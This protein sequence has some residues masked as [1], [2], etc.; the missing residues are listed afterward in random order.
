[1]SIVD[2]V[3][4]LARDDSGV[5]AS[6]FLP[7]LDDEVYW[8]VF[9]TPKCRIVTVSEIC[10]MCTYWR[11]ALGKPHVMSKADVVDIRRELEEIIKSKRNNVIRNYVHYE[12]VTLIDRQR[13]ID[14]MRRTS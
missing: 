5:Y 9:D 11:E 10:D 14:S 8:R 4:E 2:K 7:V 13:E 3:L 6:E 1:M 12:N